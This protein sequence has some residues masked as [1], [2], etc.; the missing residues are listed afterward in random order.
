LLI[1]LAITSRLMGAEI[2][3]GGSKWLVICVFKKNYSFLR[4]FNLKEVP[5]FKKKMLK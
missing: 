3:A 1:V 4:V 5:N 2:F